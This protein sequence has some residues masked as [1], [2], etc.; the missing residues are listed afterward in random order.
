MA[1]GTSIGAAHPVL[2]DGSDIQGDMRKKAEEM[3]MA[4]VRSIT[5]ERGRNAEWAEQAVKESSSLTER[6]ALEQEVIDV[7]ADDIDE[8][9]GAISGKTVQTTAGEVELEDYSQ[10][11]RIV[12]QMSLSDQAINILANPNIVALLWLAATTGISLE[13]YNPGMIFPGVVGVICLILALAVSQIIPISQGSLLL[14][15]VGS[16]LLV[17]EFFTGTV[18]LGVGGVVAI[19]IGALYLV[20]VAQAP[21]LEV[22]PEIILPFA[23]LAAGFLLITA[24]AAV[25]A[26][27]Q[28]PLTGREGLIGLKG[29][30]VENISSRGKVFVD[31]GYWDAEI[32]EGIIEKDTPIEVVGVLDGMILQV[33]SK[34]DQ[35]VEK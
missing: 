4:M 28:H 30:A 27:N 32:S 31:G 13:L 9:L 35:S 3:T 20:D 34:S 15:I 12:Y 14:M 7:V 6:E 5:A 16:I 26:R 11:P 21:G 24:R 8:L 23:I 19:V 22:S 2:G 25:K 18:I 17:A 10:L 29:R 33:V 1:P